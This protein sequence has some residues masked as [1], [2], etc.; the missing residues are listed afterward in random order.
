MT[1]TQERLTSLATAAARNLATT[2]KTAPQMQAITPRWLLRVLPWVEA[3]GG[4]YRVNR[5]LAY[6]VGTGKVSFAV[7][8]DDIRVVAPT[9]A[10]LPG[11]RNVDVSVLEAVADRFTQVTYAAGEVVT[12]FGEPADQLV[13]IA[14]GKVTTTKPGKYGDTTTVGTLADG[15]HLSAQG[16]WPT[17]ATAVTPTIT[18]VLPRA[19]L[20]ELG[21]IEPDDPAP[22]HNKHG[23]ASIHLTSGHDGEPSITGT[24]VDYEL[25]PRQY[26]LSLA[27]T[28][29]RIHTRVADLYN[30]P[31]N[32]TEH[33]LRLT[34][35]A[36]RE[37]QEHELLNNPDFGLLHNADLAQRIPTRSGPP[38]PD[39]MDNLLARRKK[40]QFF[41]AHPLAIA[42]FG[43][44]C[45]ARGI[46]PTEVTYDGKAVRAWRG[47]PLL[48]CDKI[49][50]TG[51]HTTSVIAMRTGEDNLGVVGL[52][53]TGL[54]DE[55]EPGV[56]VRF[57]GINEQAVI[58]Y[59]VTAYHSAA[60]LVPDALGVLEHVEVG[61]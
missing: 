56:S 8:G 1:S 33:Q 26:E 52:R 29:L 59:L 36:L 23:E 24:F 15:G 30:E 20:A 55:Y 47:V 57:I 5:R 16:T 54:P 53:Q 17:T 31:H 50:V 6:P 21:P 19:T 9:L 10:E 12:R 37:R 34:V 51:H 14:H 46:Y 2:T 35:E 25:S 3:T 44:E 45:T 32:Q 22:H 41:L 28:I 11:L 27:Q 58:S 61:R 13:L 7:T 42:A 18:L 60:I 40:T 48:P 38:T 49:P 39:D 43:R 4:T